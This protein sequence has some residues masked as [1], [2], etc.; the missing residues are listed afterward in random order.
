[1]EE[2]SVPTYIDQWISVIENMKNENTYKLAWGRALVECVFHDRYEKDI[3]GQY[4][5]SLSSIAEC[6]LRY[7]WNQT[8]FFH[9]RQSPIRKDQRIASIVRITEE[10]IEK[11]KAKTK[12]N[13]P[14]WFD[15]VQLELDVK[16]Y[17]D[18]IKKIAHVLPNDVSWR[19]KRVNNEFLPIYEYDE[20]K[21][22]SYVIFKEEEVKY[23]KSYAI[24][25][26]K[27]LNYKWAQLLERFNY[28][29]NIVKKVNSI[30]ETNIPRNSS[31]IHQIRN[32][33]LKQFQGGDPID[34]YSGEILQPEEIS[35]DHVIPWS[36]M[37]SDDIWNLVLTSRSINSSK[38]NSIPSQQTIDRLKV[39]NDQIVDLLDDKYK[40]EMEA[41]IQNHF[42]DK[43]FF[44][45]RM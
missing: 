6:M 40:I 22:S 23:I 29:P 41:A 3:F 19:F 26:S 36:F 32:E 20:T 34:F 2:I 10:L 43:Y 7:Y 38:S 37:Y 45:S 9:L 31:A 5:V 21:R 35:L 12:S 39:R 15:R 11:Y 33:L 30:S 25:L 4:L 14:V 28:S 42:V 17:Q 1:M 16:D 13:I 18:A 27:L 44:E 8:F 24:V